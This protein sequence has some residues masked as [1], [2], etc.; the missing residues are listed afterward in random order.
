METISDYTGFSDG[1]DN[2]P[3]RPQFLT[4]LCILSFIGIGLMLAFTIIGI[5]VNT[6]ERQTEQIEQLRQLSPSMADQM[7]EQVAA[8]QESV[9]YKV[10]NYINLLF[11][12]GSFLG[13]LQMWQLK[14]TGLYIYAIAELVPYLFMIIGGKEAMQMFGSMGGG[15]MQSILYAVLVLL[16]VFDSAFVVM[17][18]VN[19]KHMK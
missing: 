4:V 15:G 19:L 6:P 17:Y 18:A 7:E 10:Q 2:K 14:K 1:A 13:V 3:K 5:I 12:L 16:F 9:L 11:L 8:Q